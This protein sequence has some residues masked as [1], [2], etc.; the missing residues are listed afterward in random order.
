[1]PSLVGFR[2]DALTPLLRTIRADETSLPVISTSPF[3]DAGR[4]TIE[5]ERI[6][7]TSKTPTSFEG[8]TRGADLQ[9][10]GT[11]QMPHPGGALVSQDTPTLKG[12]VHDEILVPQRSALALIEGSG[13][14]LTL[15]DNPARERS[16][17]TVASFTQDHGHT[18]T[19]DGG[20]IPSTSVT[21]LGLVW[22]A[23]NSPSAAS[24]SSFDNVF[25]GAYENYLVQI[26]VAES[27]A[28]AQLQGR[29]RVSGAD[30]SSSS[31]YSEIVT[32][33]SASS[34]AAAA[35]NTWIITSAPGAGVTN[36]D[37]HLTLFVYRPQIADETLMSGFGAFRF[38][39]PGFRGYLVGG[40]YNA[41]TQYDGCTIFPSSGNITGTIRVYGLRD[42]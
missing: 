3:Q 21:G 7:Y 2:S 6:R 42:S 1:M 26:D 25:T 13:I 18:V 39:T 9:E 20:L 11:G 33:T 15:V 4:I 8:C 17:V 37:V 41:T 24:T 29:L 34:G 38:S 32:T 36:T 14:D 28:N 35:A 16:E 31:Y 22:L 19:G 5:G 23:T 40:G 12:L 27:A 30:S 10:G